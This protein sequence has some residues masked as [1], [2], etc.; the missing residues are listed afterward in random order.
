MLLP[1]LALAVAQGSQLDFE[2]SV[3]AD[4]VASAHVTYLVSRMIHRWDCHKGRKKGCHISSGQSVRFAKGYGVRIK[5]D[6]AEC[7]HLVGG[8]DET[9]TKMLTSGD[10]FSIFDICPALSRASPP[11]EETAEETAYSAFNRGAARINVTVINNL[12]APVEVHYLVS[13]RIQRWDCALTTRG[14]R[15]SC[16]LEAGQ[17]ARILKGFGLRF[18]RSKQV[19]RML[20]DESCTILT[21]E[22]S[23]AA[24]S[25][26]TSGEEVYMERVCLGRWTPGRPQAPTR[27]PTSRTAPG[28]RSYGSRSG[29]RRSRRGRGSSRSDRARQR[30]QQ[31]QKKKTR[32]GGAGVVVENESP[33]PVTCR[34][35]LSPA[36]PRWEAC[37]GTAGRRSPLLELGGSVHIARL[38]AKLSFGR[39]NFATTTSAVE[40]TLTS[41]PN[42]EGV[43]IEDGDTVSVKDACAGH[44]QFKSSAPAAAQDMTPYVAADLLGIPMDRLD[45][46]LLRRSYRAAI[47]RWH[48]DR[49]SRRLEEANF[50]TSRINDAKAKLDQHLRS[51]RSAPHSAPEGTADTHA[52]EEVASLYDALGVAMTASDAEID[53][54]LAKLRAALLAGE[55]AHAVLSDSARRRTYDGGFTMLT[56]AAA[57][58]LLTTVPQLRPIVLL[59]GTLR[60]SSALVRAF[61][62][63][64]LAQL[65]LS[66][67][68]D[69][70]RAD[71]TRADATRANASAS[72]LR[73]ICA[74]I[75]CSRS[76]ALCVRVRERSGGDHTIFLIPP[77]NARTATLD[78]RT[79]SALSFESVREEGDDAKPHAAELAEFV[80]IFGG[81]TTGQYLAPLTSRSLDSVVLDYDAL[82]VG[83][84][85]STAGEASETFRLKR[86]ARRIEADRTDG[87]GAVRI[88]FCDCGDEKDRGGAALCRAQRIFAD[89]DA[90]SQRAVA[91][92]VWAHGTKSKRYLGAAPLERASASSWAQQ[93]RS[94]VTIAYLS[95]GH[96]LPAALLPPVN[97]TAETERREASV[98]ISAFYTRCDSIVRPPSVVHSLCGLLLFFFCLLFFF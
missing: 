52:E 16:T 68:A 66:E 6:G 55:A 2:L 36:N 12:G 33:H 87:R 37:T 73:P 77:S 71:A 14:S 64:S 91:F 28:T 21:S 5:L 56:S 49:N 10:L 75:D 1:L 42:R 43:G 34:M 76:G 82:V 57:K 79:Q 97:A 90:L 84:F 25:S 15:S 88:V 67:G 18:T 60:A 41:A 58:A 24:A 4:A 86:I 69:A 74:F 8:P 80:S 26:V 95:T 81:D 48:P 35:K 65:T 98:A 50:W 53:S 7:T 3:P 31:Q 89:D 30:P 59:V 46:A 44:W 47:L 51:V 54:A 94:L 61:R 70:T 19:G 78:A 72:A 29:R 32:R 96:P 9:I 92:R 85:V 27:G 83:V 62:N 93:L 63:Y 13:T 45:E 22:A 11:P 39:V 23:A 40:C 17:S 20:R 38:P